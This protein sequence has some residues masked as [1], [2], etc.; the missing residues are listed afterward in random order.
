MPLIL[1]I[2][3]AT[4][5][6]SVAIANNGILLSE[7]SHEDARSHASQLTLLIEKICKQLS[8]EYA[9]LD[10][11]AVS[12]GPGSYTG[13]RIG[14]ATAKG[15]AYALDKPLIAVN[16]LESY[17]FDLKSKQEELLKPLNHS[18]L[19][20]PMI[21]AR[22]MEVYSALFNSEIKMVREI[23]AEI[24]TEQSFSH[25]L[26]QHPVIFFGNGAA[27][28]KSFLGQKSNAIFIDDFQPSANGQIIGAYHS[29][30]QKQFED[31]A[32]FEPYY[33]KEFLG[34]KS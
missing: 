26:N 11:I 10:A 2:E 13:L 3:T 17:A 16:T 4:D 20:C 24:I 30:L 6:C 21:D 15:L 33:L 14:V 19:L 29:F 5:V 34:I 18:Y 25:E 31:I 9:H 8:I 12:K 27:K 23:R 7:L 28:C 32:Y 1:H 22:R